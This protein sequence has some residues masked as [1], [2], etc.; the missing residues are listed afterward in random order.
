M[1]KAYPPTDQQ[2]SINQQKSIISECRLL[3]EK[4]FAEDEE[5]DEYHPDKILDDDDDEFD[6]VECKFTDINKSFKAEDANGIANE[7]VME[8]NDKV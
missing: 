6:D 7:I 5:D 2:W 8:F 1:L 3:L 4:E